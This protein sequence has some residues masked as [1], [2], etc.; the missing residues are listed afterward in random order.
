MMKILTRDEARNVINKIF[1]YIDG[2]ND[3]D[4]QYD[5][6][7]G[8]PALYFFHSKDEF[9]KKVEEFLLTKDEFDRYDIY[10]FSNKMIKFLV[11]PYDSH[12]SVTMMNLE[13][14][15]IKFK[16]IDGKICVIKITKPMENALFGELVSIN[17]IDIE[18]IKKEI[19]EMTSY[20][21]KEFLETSLQADLKIPEIMKSLPIFDKETSYIKYTIL[22]NGKLIEHTFNLE[23]INDYPDYNYT[24]KENYTYEVCDDVLVLTYNSCRDIE[25]MK[26]FV[27]KITEVSKKEK[28]NK[29]IVDLRGN[30]GGNSGVIKPLIEF[31]KGKDIVTLI[32]EEIFSSGSMACID[33]RNIGSY[34]VGTNIST[35]LNAFGNNIGALTLEDL[36]LG[37]KRSTKYFYFGTDLP[38]L[39]INR[40]NFSDVFK[41][42]ENF[43]SLDPLMFEPDELVYR[44]LEDYINGTDTQL[45]AAFKHLKVL[46][47]KMK[48]D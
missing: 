17:G 1:D 32:D 38:K 25:A 21:T 31:L 37:V 36:D 44:P 8:H 3:Y 41:T 14:L 4:E 26:R 28:I 42:K 47:M 11:G 27:E 20:S 19:E 12:T 6:Y 29:F 24:Y 30:R 5:C 46:D 9:N 39:A 16:I 35:T 13:F 33:L 10:Y 23:Q 48:H 40:T 2:T 18:T 22:K 43:M 45:E 15:P 7:L 34:F